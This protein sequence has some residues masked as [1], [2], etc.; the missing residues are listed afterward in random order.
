[1]FLQ[2]LFTIFISVTF[3]QGMN[4]SLCFSAA[5]WRLPLEFMGGWG[6]ALKSQGGREES[7]SAHGVQSPTA[8]LFR[9]SGSVPVY[10]A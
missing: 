8:C 1:M 6:G 9:H 5:G 3:T 4:G 2:T 7:A 10:P